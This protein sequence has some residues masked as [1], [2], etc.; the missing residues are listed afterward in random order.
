M[1]TWPS[2]LGDGSAGRRQL[3]CWRYI[4][5]KW[6]LGGP[7]GV[8]HCPFY[9]P[10][11]TSF[12]SNAERRK[13]EEK[14]K[15]SYV[16]QPTS[17]FLCLLGVDLCATLNGRPKRADRQEHGYEVNELDFKAADRLGKPMFD[18]RVAVGRCGK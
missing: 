4:A 14:G 16:L 15:E 12:L 9:P 17:A 2:N 1:R 18:K 8:T 10:S 7:K 11:T 3:A 13:R 6:R 5:G